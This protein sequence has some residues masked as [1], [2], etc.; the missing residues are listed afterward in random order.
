MQ[1]LR[2]VSMIDVC[3][4]TKKLA[5]NVFDY[6]WEICGEILIYTGL[7]PLPYLRSE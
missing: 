6:R 5:I 2:V 3:K 7:E 1:N 4:H